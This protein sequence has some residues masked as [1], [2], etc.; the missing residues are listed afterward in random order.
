MPKRIKVHLQWYESGNHGTRFTS[1]D[2]A[3]KPRYDSVGTVAQVILDRIDTMDETLL[4][5]VTAMFNALYTRR[6]TIQLHSPKVDGLGELREM[7][8]CE[9]D[10]SKLTV[11]FCERLLRIS[12][13]LEER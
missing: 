7:A 13:V 1:K 4:Y 8:K 2:T 11:I 3:M 12:D 9:V 5:W 6:E 10:D